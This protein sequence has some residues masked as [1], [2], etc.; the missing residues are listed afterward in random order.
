MLDASVRARVK[1]PHISASKERFRAKKRAR[2][3]YS[4]IVACFEGTERRE[5]REAATED[6]KGPVVLGLLVGVEK[7]KQG[8]GSRRG[9]G[10]GREGEDGDIQL[11]EGSVDGGAGA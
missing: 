6:V 3:A 7:G 4:K 8:E 10:R 5:A 1:R 11:S 2:R 9:V